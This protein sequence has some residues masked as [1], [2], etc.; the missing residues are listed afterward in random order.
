MQKINKKKLEKK[1]IKTIKIIFF[2]PQTHTQNRRSKSKKIY[3]NFDQKT[4]KKIN[5]KK[6]TPET[7]NHTILAP[8]VRF[9]DIRNQKK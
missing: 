2:I 8:H 7:N 9:F 6:F 1:R 5:K 4:L 3:K